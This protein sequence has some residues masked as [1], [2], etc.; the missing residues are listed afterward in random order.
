MKKK[1]ALIGMIAGIFTVILGI[2]ATIGM[3]GN[4]ND[5]DDCCDE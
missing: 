2:I 4:S 1:F 3:F 5:E